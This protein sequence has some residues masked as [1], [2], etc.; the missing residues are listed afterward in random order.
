MESSLVITFKSPPFPYFIES[1]SHT[2]EVGEEHPNRTNIGLFDMI[3][4]REG[5]LYIG[6]GDHR[7]E[8]RRGEVLILRPD[9][10]HY[11][12]A[13]CSERTTFDWLHFQSA[14]P[15]EEIESSEQGVLRGDYYTYALRVPKHIKLQ[16]TNE[17]KSLLE[18]LHEA[19]RN[20]SHGAFWDRQQRFLHLLQMLDE[21]WRSDTAK[22][23]V[24]VAEKAAAFLKRNYRQSISNQML[25]DALELH[26][27]YITRSM[28]EVFD[29]TPQ[30]Y[31]LYYRIDQAKLL[32]IKTDWPISQIALESGFKQTAHFSR[33]F[34]NQVGL[35]PLRYR[36]KFTH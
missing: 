21:G 16:A 20:S 10:W 31:L 34:A 26:I 29:C 25:S 13:P 19:A 24:I 23:S 1:N 28:S 6:E 30:Q 18:A 36:K 2:Y 8:L 3:Y 12:Y 27:N 32:L 11:S 17:M 33:L 15:W 4:V 5:C 9:A 14:G 35:S 22:A 7:W